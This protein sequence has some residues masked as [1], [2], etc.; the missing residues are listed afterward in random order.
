MPPHEA[1]VRRH[2]CCWELTSASRRSPSYST[3]ASRQATL[4]A[5]WAHSTLP[6]LPS[7]PFFSPSLPS[8]F[9][10]PFPSHYSIAP[11][12]VFLTPLRAA[13]TGRL[14]AHAPSTRCS[15][16]ALSAM[17][18]QSRHGCATTRCRWGASRMREQ[19]ASSSALS[20]MG[21][22]VCATPSLFR[23]AHGSSCP[24]LARLGDAAHFHSTRRVTLGPLP[25]DGTAAIP[26][27]AAGP[28]GT[29]P[30]GATWWV[31]APRVYAPIKM[32][33]ALRAVVHDSDVS[34]GMV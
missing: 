12:P 33:Y 28:A 7:S 14:R 21:P 23:S 15:D 31:D 24:F 1:V 34:F 26:F 19:S 8:L 9:S 25:L 6:R 10:L 32:F 22:C 5:R 30:P 3:A 18:T 13:R 11:A 27:S 29:Q 17:S 16:G 2:Q 20:H 4:C